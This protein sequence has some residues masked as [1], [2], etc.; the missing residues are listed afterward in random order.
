MIRQLSLVTLSALALTFAGCT[1]KEE[2]KI[3]TDEQKY[4][5]A[6]GF[7]FANNLKNQGLKVDVPALAQAVSHVLE[8]QEP[9]L[10]Q[11]EMEE[12]MQKMYQAQQEQRQKEAVENKEAGQKFLEGNREKEGVQ[13]TDS[14][15]Q[16]KIIEE[17]EG[18][19]PR[20][21]QSVKV[22][23]RGT[24]IDGTEFDSSYRRN[25]PAEFPVDG[26]IPGWVEALKMMKSGAK[27][28]L[29]IPAE[30]AYGERGRPGIPPN[31]VLIFEVELLEIN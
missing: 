8:G 26:V 12:A 24:L 2:T 28:E 4:S 7:N 17:G 6:I 16:Y 20:A 27:W 9:V 11:A 19:S 1:K 10:T 15:L 30:L 5:Y 23:Y 25:A 22:H 21:G 18:V 13:V 29:Y 14:G 31:S 3:E